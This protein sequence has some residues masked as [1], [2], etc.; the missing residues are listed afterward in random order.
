MQ[1][2]DI[3]FFVIMTFLTLYVV[4]RALEVLT[5]VI[6]NIVKIRNDYRY[7]L[8]VEIHNLKVD[9]WNEETEL[10]EETK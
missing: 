9:E 2:A 6:Q 8:E 7:N 1:I 5:N 10:E 3:Q 4:F